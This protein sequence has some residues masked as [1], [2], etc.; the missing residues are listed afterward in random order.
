MLR[1]SLAKNIIS[2]VTSLLDEDIIVVDISGVIIAST[3]EKR[4][5]DC[6]EGALIVCRT[7][8]KLTITKADEAKL[9]GVKAGINLPIFFN[10]KII[11]IIGITGEPD[12]V[13][14]Y[15][16]LLRK[17]T[18]LLV[19][20]NYYFEQ[21]EWEARSLEM[22]V[23]DWIQQ[24]EWSSSFLS[25]SQLLSIDLS[26]D[27][28]VI[29]GH[30][31]QKEGNFISSEI[32]NDVIKNFTRI[33]RD[34]FVR[35]GTER[36]LIIRSRKETKESTQ[37]FLKQIQIYF[38]DKYQQIVSFGVG[39]LT[40]SN[41]LYQ[42]FE[43]AERALNV[44]IRKQSIIFDDDLRLEMCLQDI[45]QHTRLE[46]VDRTVAPI[47][48]DQELIHTIEAFISNNQSIKDSAK[49]LHIHINTLH[50]RFKKIEKLTNLNP[51]DFQD[52]TTLYLS[53]SFLDDYL[54]IKNKN[55]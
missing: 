39:H 16:E 2:K 38:E 41:R 53:L 31:L 50:Y 7:S 13:S 47:M 49:A 17:M 1:P 42:S 44:A 51:R 25:Q 4:I 11:G 10:E 6:H 48:K 36:F 24:K 32:W 18:E 3:N 29:I 22:F 27:R 9:K 5:G 35:W 46:L 28:Q 12:K 26:S 43:Q 21:L 54:K 23:F 15:G 33:K 20:E 19:K 52:L 30:Y 8:V 55:T 34:I 40:A 37:H 45:Q 14:S